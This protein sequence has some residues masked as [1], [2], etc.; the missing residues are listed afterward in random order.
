M[1]KTI[2]WN[3][4]YV[5][6]AATVGAIILLVLM[7]KTNER[8][9][10]K[11]FV[12]SLAVGAIFAILYVFLQETKLTNATGEPVF[13]KPEEGDNA[14]EVAPNAKR[15]GLDGVKTGDAVYKLT[16]G[17]HANVTQTGKVSIQSVFGTLMN[18]AMGGGKLTAPP[19][20]GWKNLFEK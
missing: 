19:N 13:V 5:V 17:T 4:G 12:V 8:M 6:D 10:Q 9:Y 11:W 1:K 14:E 18:L 20:Q 3:T 7:V 2:K 15:Y 16:D